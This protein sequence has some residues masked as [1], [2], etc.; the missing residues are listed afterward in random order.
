MAKSSEEPSTTATGTPFAL[1]ARVKLY[2]LVKAPHLNEKTGIVSSSS[3]NKDGRQTVHIPEL[4]K[5]VSLKLCNMVYEG[6]SIDSLSIREMKTVLTRKSNVAESELNGIDK[7]EVRK[8]VGELGLSEEEIA[9]IVYS[10]ESS[11]SRS[12]PI[13][14]NTTSSNSQ[15]S[16]NPTA[17]ADQLSSMSPEQLRQ[18]AQMMRSMDPSTLRVMNP[19]MAHLSD[20]QIKSAADQMEMMSNNPAMMKMAVDQVK[21]MSHEDLDGAR[22][23]FGGISNNEKS[24]SATSSSQKQAQASDLLSNM[25]PE[26]LRQQAEM[27]R[28]M[29]MDTL[30]ATN[31]Q[32]MGNMNDDQIKSAINQISMMADNPELV[33]AAAEKMKNIS[34]D[35]MANMAGAGAGKLDPSSF[36]ESAAS[37]DPAMMKQ[38]IEML[39]CNPEMVK[40]FAASTGMSEDQVN[41]T[42]DMFGNMSD[43]QLNKTLGF[44][45]KMQKLKSSGAAVWTA[46]DKVFMGQLSKVLFALLFYGLFFIV[47]KVLLRGA[48]GEVV[49]GMQESIDDPVPVLNQDE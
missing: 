18:Q 28:S 10:A 1:H 25:T 43:D 32:M 47:R 7:S 45:V 46:V 41:K 37:M 16:T 40:Q 29:D 33:K 19:Q 34:P 30:R 26:Q 35:D 14:S 5:T 15:S 23:R 9:E 6:R 12:S 20:A 48:G 27:M 31:P 2:G 17:V 39:K 8:K 42:I 21:N 24:T 38:S 3:V 22:S 49:T 4:N 11:N 13:A 44:M 36:A